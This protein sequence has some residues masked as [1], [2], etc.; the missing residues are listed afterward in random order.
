MGSKLGQGDIFVSFSGRERLSWEQGTSPRCWV[1]AEQLL[2]QLRVQEIAQGLQLRGIFLES[3]VGKDPL[4]SVRTAHG[5]HLL[6]AK[7]K[8]VSE[9]KGGLGEQSRVRSWPGWALD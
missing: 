6:L 3:A 1:M 4:A 7:W 9:Q 2:L 8:Q 5:F